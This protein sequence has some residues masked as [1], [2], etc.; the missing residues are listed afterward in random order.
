MFD[1]L[2]LVRGAVVQAIAFRRLVGLM[3]PRG[4]AVI[5]DCGGSGST[6]DSSNTKMRCGEHTPDDV[7]RWDKT[8]N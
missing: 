5:E 6:R 2:N 3:G 4:P 7:L 1:S 8:F